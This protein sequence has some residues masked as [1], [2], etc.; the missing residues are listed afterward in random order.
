M[1]VAKQVIILDW[2]VPVLSVLESLL[3]SGLVYLFQMCLGSFLGRLPSQKIKADML[4]LSGC[5]RA[6]ET[7]SVLL[8]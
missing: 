1:H 7:G 5:H 2:P 3:H 6:T 8:S 4:L